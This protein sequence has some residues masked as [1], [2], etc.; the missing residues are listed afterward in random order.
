MRLPV[1]SIALGLKDA[2]DSLDEVGGLTDG[3]VGRDVLVRNCV[4]LLPALVRWLLVVVQW[5]VDLGLL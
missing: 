1:G 5:Y 3:G 2:V 4:H